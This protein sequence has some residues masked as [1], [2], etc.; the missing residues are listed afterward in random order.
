LTIRLV[1]TTTGDSLDLYC[2][3]FYYN[4]NSKHQL[5]LLEQVGRGAGVAG[6]ASA[7]AW[8][9]GGAKHARPAVG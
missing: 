5:A 2:G 9:T 7:P 3:L 8:C 1:G 6:G 4:A